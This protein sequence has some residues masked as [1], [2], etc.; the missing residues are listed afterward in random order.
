MALIDGV[1]ASAEAGGG[2]RVAAG[3]GHALLVLLAG[4]GRRLARAVGWAEPGG[5][6]STGKAQVGFLLSL[7]LIFVLFSI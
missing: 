5:W 7:F 6:A 1:R 4:G 3:T 2:R